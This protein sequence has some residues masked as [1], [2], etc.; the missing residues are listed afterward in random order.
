MG[1]EGPV[2]KAAS[3]GLGM[4]RSILGCPWDTNQKRNLLGE[5]RGSASHTLDGC[6][7]GHHGQASVGK[8]AAPVR[9]EVPDLGGELQGLPQPHAEGG[10]TG[11]AMALLRPK[12][13]VP[14]SWG[15]GQP[16]GP[17][18]PVWQQLW[19]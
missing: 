8:V 2:T 7:P 12:T 10:A 5:H 11:G 4:D 3:S 18:Q 6:S 15:P 13:N 17:A 16:G 19:A 1:Q 9:G 14:Q